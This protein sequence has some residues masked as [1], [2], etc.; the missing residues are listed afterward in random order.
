MS[1]DLSVASKLSGDWSC[2]GSDQFEISIKSGEA[3]DEIIV[4]NPD[5]MH[6]SQGTGN[7]IS[8]E[9]ASCEIVVFF[10][11][12]AVVNGNP[13]ENFDRIDWDNETVWY[14]KGYEE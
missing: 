12:G 14:R 4:I 8:E 1:S 5:G 7:V 3:P 9:E 10:D 2:P 13:S 11:N 6:W